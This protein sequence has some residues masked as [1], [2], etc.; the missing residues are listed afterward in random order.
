M[1]AIIIAGVVILGMAVMF[2]LSETTEYVAP[3]VLEIEEVEV[4][5]TEE[6]LRRLEWEK[7]AEEVKAQHMKK[8]ELE[9]ERS[10]LLEEVKE[11]E[12]RIKELEKEL[13]F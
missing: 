2:S 8:K 6:E 5:P 10:V 4:T 13:G 3:E 12:A 7:E 9:H 11:R 1:K